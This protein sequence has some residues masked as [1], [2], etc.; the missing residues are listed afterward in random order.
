MLKH[1]ESLVTLSFG[2]VMPIVGCILVCPQL[3]CGMA[4]EYM[5]VIGVSTLGL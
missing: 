2:K 5:T 3:P 1:V 4:V